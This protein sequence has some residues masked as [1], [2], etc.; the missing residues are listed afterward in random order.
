MA[1]LKALGPHVREGRVWSY[2]FQ[3]SY[4][5]TYTHMCHRVWCSVKSADWEES[6]DV[7]ILSNFLSDPLTS[8]KPITFFP[9]GAVSIS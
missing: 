9:W 4:T 5:N 6:G 1:P 3:T 2:F 7:D 8:G